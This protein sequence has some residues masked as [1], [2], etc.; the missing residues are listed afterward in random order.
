MR[1]NSGTFLAFVGVTMAISLTTASALLQP[2]RRSSSGIPYSRAMRSM[3]SS[4]G[5][6]RS[7]SMSVRCA[8]AIASLIGRRIVSVAAL[9]RKQST[10]IGFDEA[11]IGMNPALAITLDDGV[12]VIPTADPEGNGP[13]WMEILAQQS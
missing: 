10:A 11:T 6:R 7:F 3:R 1:R 13:G 2:E 5:V 4:D 12:L 8:G 9:T